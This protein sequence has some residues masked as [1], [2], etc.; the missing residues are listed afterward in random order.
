MGGYRSYERMVWFYEDRIGRGE[1]GWA[2]TDVDGDD[3]WNQSPD[4]WSRPEGPFLSSEQRQQ[5]GDSTA[6]SRAWASAMT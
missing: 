2:D 5:T 1:G 6:R 3:L 4:E